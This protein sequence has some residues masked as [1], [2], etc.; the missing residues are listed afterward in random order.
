[1]TEEPDGPPDEPYPPGPAPATGEDA[2]I[3][4]LLDDRPGNVNQVLGVAEA[5][6][7]PFTHKNLSYGLLARIPS[8]LLGGS[9]LG[10]DA[11]SRKALQAPWPD[12]VIAAG[13][14]AAMV[15]RW[16][17]VRS[18]GKTRLA[19]M[20]DPGAGREAF[21]L[22]VLPRHDRGVVDRPNLLLVTGAPHRVTPEKLAF[23][24]KAWEGVFDGLPRP[25]L[26]L[27]VGGPTKDQGFPDR[28]WDDLAAW[29]VVLA[30]S[31]SGS[32]LVSTSRRTGAAATARLRAMIPEPRAFH[33]FGDAASNPYM[34]YLAQ[35]DGI[36]VTGDSVSMMCEAVATGR[37]VW[38]FAPTDLLGP[39][40][41]RLAADLFA[42]GLARPLMAH[43]AWYEGKGRAHNAA[44]DVARAIVERGL[45]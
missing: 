19:H 4:A 9:V 27:L 13:R 10:V 32:L 34:G 36:I 21:D 18:G 2:R 12:V 28:H 3:W 29:S 31:V 14:R 1:M 11:E 8:M 23:E 5:L 45:L 30:R 40:H 17:K 20:M 43:A 33:A 26:A 25:H 38:I 42:Q 37:P 44:A 35:A 16:I 6:G 41:T 39:K 22:L 24:A 15:A 7:Q